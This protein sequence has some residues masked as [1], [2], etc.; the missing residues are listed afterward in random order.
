MR[1]LTLRQ[2][3]VIRAV[4]MTG[5]I[6][7]A[8]EF[9][10]VSAPGISRLVKHTEDSLGVRL[11]E[12][13]AGLFVPAVEATPVFE[14]IH[15][16]YE[17]MSG[18]SFALARLKR[19]ADSNLVF[20]AMPS[21]AQFLAPRAVLQVRKRFPELYIDL[22]VLK[23]EE[24]V[25]YLLLERGE[26]VATSYR[27]EHPSLEF[28][29]LGEGGL[30]VILP[31][32]HR[33]A[34]ARILSVRDIADEPLVGVDGSDPY[35]QITARP[36]AMAGLERRLSV[37]ARFAQTVVSLVGHGLGVAI[38]DEFS[39]AGVQMPGLAR[40]PLAETVPVS[41]FVAQKAGRVRS[42]FADYA[43]AQLRSELRQAVARRPWVS[44]DG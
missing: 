40:I 28:Q 30:V 9:L 11:F 37:K 18:L 20:A 14:Q 21:I 13:K 43:V 38:I 34:E 27:F 2:V 29:P 10:N 25:D 36:F 19:G 31:K 7:G 16:I 15:Q 12:R 42:S 24:T 22:N 4:M 35:G 32:A 5:T 41:L 26:F 1:D 3:E 8:A 17:K 44:G 23:I 39:I 6:N 33:L